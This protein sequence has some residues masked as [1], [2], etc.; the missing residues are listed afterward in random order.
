MIFDCC[1]NARTHHTTI[2]EKYSDRRY[3]KASVF[4]EGE[5]QNGFVLPFLHRR[6][7][8]HLEAD[9]WSTEHSYEHVAAVASQTSAQASIGML[10]ASEG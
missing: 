4:V 10:I 6:P 9:E 1:L 7:Q 5:I 8:P 3:K 2:F